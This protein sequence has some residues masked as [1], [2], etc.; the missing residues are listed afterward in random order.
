[1]IR[2]VKYFKQTTNIEAV[3]ARLLEPTARVMDP[4]TELLTISVE[5]VSP[6]IG[7]LTPVDK[8]APSVTGLLSPVDKMAPSVTEPPAP[9]VVSRLW[10]LSAGSVSPAIELPKLIAGEVLLPPDCRHQSL[11]QNHWPPHCRHQWSWRV[12]SIVSWPS[13]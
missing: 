6:V 8:M 9:V 1:M 4:A 7:P 5:A 3:G 2:Q 13:N 12:F 11:E 10:P